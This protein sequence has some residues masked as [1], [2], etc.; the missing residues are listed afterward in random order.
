M[1]RGVFSARCPKSIITA[2]SLYFLEQF[3]WWKQCGGGVVWEMDAKSA[4]ALVTLE[5]AWQLE[6]QSEQQ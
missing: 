3:R 2:Q 4:D 5:T 1:R 6:K